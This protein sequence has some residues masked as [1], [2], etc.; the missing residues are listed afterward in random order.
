MLQQAL[1]EDKIDLALIPNG[2]IPIVDPRLAA[3]AVNSDRR[4]DILIWRYK[5]EKLE[6]LSAFV[7]SLLGFAAH[8]VPAAREGAMRVG[9]LPN[10]TK[11]R[12]WFG[13]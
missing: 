6:E 3:Q 2:I 13:K 4:E 5:K 8:F 10:A 11:K 12:K 7:D 1:N 9:L